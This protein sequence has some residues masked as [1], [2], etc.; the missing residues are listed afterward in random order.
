M[1]VNARLTV[2]N[3]VEEID[4]CRKYLIV[5]SRA[6]VRDQLWF[7]TVA[8]QSTLFDLGDENGARIEAEVRRCNFCHAKDNT[9]NI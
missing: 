1:L 9:K 6:I 4:A 2:Q 5:H 8:S 3:L 7:L